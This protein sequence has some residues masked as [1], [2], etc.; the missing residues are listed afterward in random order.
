MSS[1]LWITSL[2]L[3]TLT[4]ADLWIAGIYLPQQQVAV[5]GAAFRLVLLVAVPLQ[6]VNMVVAPLIA[7]LY[8]Q[9]KREELERSLRVAATVTGIPSFLTLVA[10]ML[11]GKPIL[12]LVFGG[13]YREGA[14][15]LALLSVGQLVNVWTGSCVQTL[16]MTG[17]QAPVMNAT[18]ATGLLI[19]TGALWAG[20]IYGAVGIAGAV[21]TGKAFQNILMLFYARKRTG[22]W[23]HITFS[24]SGGI[25]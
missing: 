7:E 2:I 16:M 17:N 4:Q 8:T 3:F 19:I 14:L 9:G 1:P 13:Y 15:I 18:I 25:R 5:Y 11:F 24:S 20:H 22:I 10:F 12:G 23:T 6:I 21:A